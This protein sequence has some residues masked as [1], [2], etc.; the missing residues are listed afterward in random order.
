M[1]RSRVQMYAPATTSFAQIRTR[2]AS[3]DRRRHQLGRGA[4]GES[5]DRK[6]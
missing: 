2:E 1:V 3:E 4:E 5:A 6:I